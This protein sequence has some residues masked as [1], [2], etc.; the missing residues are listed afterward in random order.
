MISKA[1]SLR[2]AS[3]KPLTCENLPDI[4]KPSKKCEF[5]D[6]ETGHKIFLTPIR[7]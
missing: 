1:Y 3:N 2:V 7:E 5:C 6:L 4:S